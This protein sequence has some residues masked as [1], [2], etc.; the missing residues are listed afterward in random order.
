MSQ[1][2][3]EQGRLPFPGS[4]CHRCRHARY[5]GNRRGSVF[6]MCQAL[7]QKYQPQPVLRC[8]AFEPK[9]GGGR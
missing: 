1:G 7:P 5:V 3:D 6:L 8:G 9:P 4:L 2:P